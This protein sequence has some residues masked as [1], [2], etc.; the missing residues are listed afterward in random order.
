MNSKPATKKARA[1]V[2]I[3]IATLRIFVAWEAGFA[4]DFDTT[5]ATATEE[6]RTA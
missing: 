5:T 1:I 4:S 2:G 6:S 3:A